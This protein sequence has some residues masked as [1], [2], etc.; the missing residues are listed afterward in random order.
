MSEIAKHKISALVANQY[1][2][3]F[4]SLNQKIDLL[5]GHLNNDFLITT[6]KVRR[7]NT[8]ARQKLASGDLTPT[9]SGKISAAVKSFDTILIELQYHDIIRQKL[10]HIYTVEAALSKE[11]NLIYEKQGN[12][13]D[14]HYT[15]V[16]YD[17]MSLAYNQLSHIRREYMF[18]SN[19]IQKF[20]R[21]LWADREIAK[22]LELF[23]F[24]TAENLKNVLNALDMI[25][26]MHQALRQEN[27]EFEIQI[28]EEQRMKILNEVKALYTMDSEREVFNETFGIKE[29]FVTNDEIFF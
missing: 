19:K 12:F 9:L 7:Y 22:T 29:E 11:F 4:L 13:V 28:P 21:R 26:K 15:L 25:I 27:P 14:S 23:L 18:S 3:L 17:L 2:S 8:I 6:N 20:L 5:Y 16:M 24:N 10:E 1:A